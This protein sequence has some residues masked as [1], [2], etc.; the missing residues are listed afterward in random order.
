MEAANHENKTFEKISFS[1]KELRNRTFE[2][3]EFKNCD[4]S[5]SNLSSNSFNEC[6]F[7][8][9][10]MALTKLNKTKLTDVF[11][12]ECKL[13]GINFYECNDFMFSVKFENCLLDYASFA[14]KKMAKTKFMNCSL[15]EAN[16]SNADISGVL[17]Q[18]CSLEGTVFNK[19]ILKDTDFTSA[20]NYRIDPNVNFMKKAKFSKDGLEGLLTQYDI[21][22]E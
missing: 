12:K 20:F 10:N 7:N 6:V 17:F 11:F 16:F 14:A 1:Q 8:N 9:C 22:V 13:I 19:T 4:F 3:C 18:N 15:K 5:N 21:V 2:K